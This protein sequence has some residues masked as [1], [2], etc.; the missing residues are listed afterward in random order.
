MVVD[1][2]DGVLYAAQEDVG[3]WRVPLSRNGFGQ[4]SLVDRVRGYGQP[5]TYDEAT[6][7]C[8]PTAPA[9]PSA[10]KHLTADAEGLTIA[11]PTRG[12][13]VLLASSQGD[14][15]FARYH[16]ERGGLRYV[17]GFRVV[18]SRA[19]DGVEHSDG[20]AVTLTPLGK[21]FPHGLLVVHDGENTPTSTDSNGDV[22][23]NTNF[24]LLAPR[25][26]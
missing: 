19:T 14:S 9:P 16:I 11:Y 10:G 21:A 5:A 24:K 17:S 1:R 2:T 13:R 7:E 8:V 12:S 26:R 3:I 6:E 18:T 20:A 23:P 4:P 25:L 22:R 15:T